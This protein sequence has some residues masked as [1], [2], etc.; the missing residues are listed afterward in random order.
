[1]N[2]YSSGFIELE[3]S[4]YEPSRSQSHMRV[5]INIYYKDFDHLFLQKKKE[6]LKHIYTHT[7]WQIR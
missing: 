7:H 5:C 3:I 2:S 1:M 6:A 4:T